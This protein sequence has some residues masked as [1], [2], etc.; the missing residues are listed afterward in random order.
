[1]QREYEAWM[2]EWSGEAEQW[3]I[4]SSCQVWQDPNR[5]SQGQAEEAWQRRLTH[6]SVINP[7]V[8]T[9][10]S[11]CHRR[12]HRDWPRKERETYKEDNGEKDR[13]KHTWVC[14]GRENREGWRYTETIQNLY[15]RTILAQNT[16]IPTDIQN[17]TKHWKN[18]SMETQEAT[19]SAKPLYTHSQTWVKLQLAWES[20]RK[21]LLLGLLNAM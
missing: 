10:A 20:D 8:I 11:R 15:H 16:K 14:L 12:Q 18:T 3:C 19:S 9:L 5:T 17:N 7:S 21:H 4:T 2:N 1:M 13:N 6:N